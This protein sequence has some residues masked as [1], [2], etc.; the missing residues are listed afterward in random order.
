GPSGCGKTTILRLVA[1]LTS[2]DGGRVLVAGQAVTRVTPRVGFLFQQDALL[3]WRTVHDNVALGLRLRGT[4]KDEV[5]RRVQHWLH[6]VGLAGFERHY[7][8][9][10]SGGMRKRVAIAQ[11]LICEPEVILLDVSFTNLDAQVW[12]FLCGDFL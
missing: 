10:L 3:P 6:V 5:K 4:P 1:G 11:T 12:L 7:P 9:Q 8:A 2:A